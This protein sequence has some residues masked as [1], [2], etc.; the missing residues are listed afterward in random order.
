MA[1]NEGDF[2]KTTIVLIN[3]PRQKNLFILKWS[4]K[5]FFLSNSNG[6]FINFADCRGNLYSISIIQEKRVQISCVCVF[7][8]PSIKSFF[9]RQLLAIILKGRLEKIAKSL[10][11][12]VDLKFLMGDYCGDLDF[13]YL[14]N[15]IQQP[16]YGVMAF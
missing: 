13:Y 8:K 16:I 10:F 9:G 3:V 15:E 7:L 1:F 4:A 11:C 6:I 14:M 12:L 2:P 5:I